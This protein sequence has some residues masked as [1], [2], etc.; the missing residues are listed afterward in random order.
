MALQD[1]APETEHGLKPAAYLTDL[2]CLK[3]CFLNCLEGIA[4][5]VTIAHAA[6]GQ[7]HERILKT[8]HNPVFRTD[9]FKEEYAASWLEHPPELT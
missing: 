9:M 6:R 7:R 1:G 3:A 5:P 2:E 4:V 8:C